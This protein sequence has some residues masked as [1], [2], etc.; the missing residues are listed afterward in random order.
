MREEDSN[1]KDTL[2]YWL[3]C[4][5]PTS[6]SYYRNVNGRMVMSKKGR[7]FL[8]Y[9][10]TLIPQR[11]ALTGKL[12]VR[13]K[14]YPP[15]RRKRDIDNHLK[16]LLDLMTKA[17]VWNDDSQVDFLSVSRED[18]V[19]KGKVSIEIWQLQEN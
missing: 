4:W 1:T 12:Y 9:G 2:V 15:D 5:P 11:E 3:N 14:L 17:G 10:L 16:A 6:N 8:Q 18:I 7:E 13:V 19:K